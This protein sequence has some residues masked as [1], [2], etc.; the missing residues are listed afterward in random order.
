L[1]FGGYNTSYHREASHDGKDI[2]WIRLRPMHYHF[3]FPVG[4]S[5]GLGDQDVL[6]AWGQKHLGVTI[7]DSG[8]TYTYFPAPLFEAIDQQ[9]QTACS[10]DGLC[11][12]KKMNI[13]TAE[14]S[15]CFEIVDPRRGSTDFPPIVLIFDQDVRVNWRPSEYMQQRSR[16]TWCYT[17]LKN[18]V[19]QTVLGISYMLHRDVI[20]DLKEQ[21]VGMANA[22]CPEHRQP[23]QEAEAPSR[24][25]A[26][27][28][29]LPHRLY[30]VDSDL[31]AE[32]GYSAPASDEDEVIVSSPVPAAL[33]EP[34]LAK[35]PRSV[36]AVLSA[37]VL[38]V[39]T[40]LLGVAR[41]RPGL[42]RHPSMA[43]EA[44]LLSAA[45]VATPAASPE[46]SE[47][48]SAETDDCTAVEVLQR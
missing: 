48:P 38:L 7:L 12:A 30:S 14:G 22:I 24:T 46:G 10:G 41:I 1:T 15:E 47:V 42:K 6:V 40:V 9:I 43:D 23:P 31:A 26:P 45:P 20:F 44:E 39:A 28:A 13:D 19:F 32:L 37:L 4:V 27:A 33:P 11:Q 17:F 3:V 2:Q 21:Q 18:N 29:P 16:N 34:I 8:T 36:V 5:V 25:L 35:I